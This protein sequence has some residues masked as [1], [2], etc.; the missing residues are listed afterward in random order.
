[1]IDHDRL[2]IV[3]KDTNKWGVCTAINNRVWFFV[4]MCKCCYSN[5]RKI[6]KN[7]LWGFLRK[8]DIYADY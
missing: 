4:R 5:F 2:L 7:E 3:K 1:M 6:P 8:M